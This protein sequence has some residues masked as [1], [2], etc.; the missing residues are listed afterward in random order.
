MF[1]WN[2]GY[3]YASDLPNQIV[4]LGYL[5]LHSK[6][7]KMELNVFLDNLQQLGN[8]INQNNYSILFVEIIVFLFNFVRF[9]KK[10]SKKERTKHKFKIFSK[11]LVKK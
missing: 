8:D 11:F 2:E 5:P 7:N 10:N 4:P 9:Y 3:I 6:P 1:K